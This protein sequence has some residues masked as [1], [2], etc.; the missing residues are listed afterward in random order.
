MTPP[1]FLRR[2]GLGAGVALVAGLVYRSIQH[3][4][5]TVPQ[6]RETCPG[7]EHL[8]FHPLWLWPYLSMFILVGLP[9]FLLDWPRAVRSFAVRLLCIAA[10][11]WLCFIVFPTACLRLPAEGQGFAYQWL[12]SID[13]PNNCL[14]CLHSALSMFTALALARGS[15]AFAGTWARLALFSWVA[16]LSLSIVALRQHTDLD[17]VVGLLLGALGSVGF[18]RVATAPARTET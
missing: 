2:L 1:D 14:P 16:L 8:P 17:T 5:G 13:R 10:T 18:P 9:W 15:S 11:G 4:P 6:L 7:W 12:L 3:L